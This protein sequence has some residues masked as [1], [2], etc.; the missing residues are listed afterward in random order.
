MSEEHITWD[1]NRLGFL[2]WQWRIHRSNAAGYSIG[3]TMSACSMT[4]Y[5]AYRNIK[6]RLKNKR[7]EKT[8]R[9]IAREARLEHL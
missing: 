9:Q 4:H 3:T 2:S 5:G 7:D 8:N 6:S 1:I